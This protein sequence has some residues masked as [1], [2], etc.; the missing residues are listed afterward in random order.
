MEKM[1]VIKFY[2]IFKK[3]YT[4]QIWKYWKWEAFWNE[5]L[6]EGVANLDWSPIKENDQTLRFKDGSDPSKGHSNLRQNFAQNGSS[7][8]K[9]ET[10]QVQVMLLLLKYWCLL[11]ATLRMVLWIITIWIKRPNNRKKRR[12]EN[13]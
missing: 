3:K 12:W 2:F 4:F 5:F 1:I 6:H 11:V 13:S 7:K 8:G 9:K 10:I